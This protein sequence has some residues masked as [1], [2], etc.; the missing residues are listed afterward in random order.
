MN[1][2]Y[3]IRVENTNIFRVFFPVYVGYKFPIN[4][5]DKVIKEEPIP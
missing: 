5:V 3:E 1:R 2:N 4:Y